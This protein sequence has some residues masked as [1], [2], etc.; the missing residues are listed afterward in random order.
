MKPFPALKHRSGSK[1]RLNSITDHAATSSGHISSARG[2]STSKG[3]ILQATL[4]KTSVSA[5]NDVELGVTAVE[6]ELSSNTAT[7]HSQENSSTGASPCHA[8]TESP[9][10]EGM[11]NRPSDIGTDM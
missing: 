1:T 7:S 4:D 2:L 5:G 9:E 6:P 8:L 10:S 3:S 11:S